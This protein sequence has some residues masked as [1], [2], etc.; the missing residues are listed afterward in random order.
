MPNDSED[1]TE[2]VGAGA[3][4]GGSLKVLPPGL[5]LTDQAVKRFDAVVPFDTSN[6]TRSGAP[7]IGPVVR[8]DEVR[9]RGRHDP[10]EPCRTQCRPVP[11]RFS[12]HR[13]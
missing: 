13:G 2:T 9:A 3:K 11:D 6:T 8:E 10:S 5:G 12:R 7:P 1:R 4:G